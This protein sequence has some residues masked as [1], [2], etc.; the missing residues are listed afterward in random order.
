MEKILEEEKWK[1]VVDCNKGYDGIFYYGVVTT[2]IF[3]RPSCRSKLPLRKNIVFFEKAGEAVERGFRPC[4]RCRPDLL[5]YDPSSEIIDMA[6]EKIKTNYL[7]EI[8]IEGLA[9]DLGI[10]RS[11]L[12]KLFKESEGVSIVDFIGK[13]RVN[14]SQEL[15]ENEG[16]RV[17]DI[18]YSVGFNSLSNYYRTFKK[19]TN[20][21]PNEYRKDY[22]KDK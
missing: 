12:N 2:G 6:K 10:S 21:S 5:S 15:L 14:R 1:A 18:A 16:L 7:R 3:C 19:Y 20:Q 13:V 17:I 9:K 11:H 22:K 4:K 8:D